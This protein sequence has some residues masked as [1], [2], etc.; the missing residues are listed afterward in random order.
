[1][2]CHGSH[3]Y[4][5]VML[6]FIPA[7][8]IRHGIWLEK[9]GG[10][11][12]IG[13]IYG[14]FFWG[15]YWGCPDSW[16]DPTFLDFGWTFLSSQQR[17]ILLI[18]ATSESPVI[19]LWTPWAQQ[20]RSNFKTPK[21]FRCTIPTTHLTKKVLFLLMGWEWQ[22]H[23]P[24][25]HFQIFHTH[26]LRQ[27]KKTCQSRRDQV[28]FHQVELFLAAFAIP[29]RMQNRRNFSTKNWRRLVHQL[30]SVLELL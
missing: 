4:T 29:E 20:L 9:W 14:I 10:I 11:K 8:W 28:P 17:S 13:L 23:Q 2:V 27:S 26:S 12:Y 24:A 19:E 7:P 30:L 15:I 21:Q 3:Q 16:P 6:A 1:M 22:H 25:Q 5:P 18:P